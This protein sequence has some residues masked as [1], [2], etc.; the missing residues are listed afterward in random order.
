MPGVRFP[1]G[2]RIYFFTNMSRLALGLFQPLVQWS[3]GVK[4]PEC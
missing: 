4:W 2:R 1:E 3:P